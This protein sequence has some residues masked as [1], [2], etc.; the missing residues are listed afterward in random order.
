M[1]PP[2]T[3][4][5]IAGI[6]HDGGVIAYPTETSYGLGCDPWNALAVRNIFVLKGRPESHPLPLILPPGDP[7]RFGI[8]MT[9]LAKRIAE[10]HWPAPLTLV[11]PATGF[12]S[13]TTAGTGTVAIRQSPHPFVVGLME[14]WDKPIVSTSANKSGGPSTTDS[15]EV[16]RIFHEKLACIVDG[17]SLPGRAGSTILDCTG[18][19]P[20]VLRQGDFDTGLIAELG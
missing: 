5:E 17:G 18:D 8:H 15:T 16:F 14:Y 12:P 7:E 13:E 6:L 20:V 2:Q 10:K 4:K 1:L 11:V 19:K 9:P 3:L